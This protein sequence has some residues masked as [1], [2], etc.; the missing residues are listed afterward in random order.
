TK[1]EYATRISNSGE[2]V[3]AAP[4]SVAQQGRE[5]VSHGCVNLSPANAQWFYGIS[6]P[7]AVVRVTGTP[8]PLTGKDTD[9]PDWNIPW[10]QWGEGW[11]SNPRHPGP[12]PG[13]LPA[14]LHPPLHEPHHRT[15]SVRVDGEHL[16]GGLL[17]LLA[18]R[19][20]QRYEHRA[21]VVAQLPDAL[22]DI[23]ERAVGQALLRLGEVA[24]RIP[25]P[26]QLLDRGHV[27]HP[28]VQERVELRH[29]PGQERAVGRDRVAAQRHRAGIRY[30]LAQV[31]EHLLLVL[32]GR[33]GRR[34]DRLGQPRAGVHLADH[35]LHAVQHLVRRGDHDVDALVQDVK[36]GVGDEHGDL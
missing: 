25:A 22:L 34:P 29:V 5:N 21:A 8:V 31:V 16:R 32:G 27:D 14:E 24:P 9:I 6:Q 2:F 33:R 3:H 23:R 36:L 1:G 19:P 35:G 15:G 4:W 20:G 10:S 11:D 28:V 30:V 18:G 17:S 12:Q 26:A 7:G 13:A